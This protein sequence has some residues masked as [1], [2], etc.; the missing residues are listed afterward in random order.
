MTW[1]HWPS[2][3]IMHLS[4]FS[5]RKWEKNL[6]EWSITELTV[7]S[8]L[9]LPTFSR[10]IHSLPSTSIKLLC[11]ETFRQN[12]SV[13]NRGG[14]MCYEYRLWSRP[15]NLFLNSAEKIRISNIHEQWTKSFKIL[16]NQ[17][18]PN[19]TITQLFLPELFCKVWER[20]A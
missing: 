3:L 4:F 16:K 8:T 7:S 20:I 10:I 17:K 18:T 11:M 9:P 13:V 14:Q 1:R 19:F 5:L 15:C 2:I 12:I 6:L